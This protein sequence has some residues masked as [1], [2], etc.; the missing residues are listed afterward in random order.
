MRIVDGSLRRETTLQGQKI[1]FLTHDV[2][3]ADAIIAKNVGKPLEMILRPVKKRR[4][5]DANAYMWV[6][7][8]KIAAATRL[9]KVQVYRSHIR[10]VGAFTDIAVINE[11][12]KPFIHNWMEKGDGWLAEIQPD[13]KIKGCKK[14]RVYYGSSQ[15][16]TKQM[17]RLI[18]NVIHEAQG[19]GIETATPD[20]VERLKQQWGVDV[21][22]N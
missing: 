5:L 8:D 11:A 15:Y 1:T 22:A 7:C 3:E 6:L 13:C 19:L 14:I 12:V 18:D 9:D 4:S 21:D 10:D 17:S 16:D 20:E 2:R